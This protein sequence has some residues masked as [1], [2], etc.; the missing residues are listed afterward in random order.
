MRQLAHNIKTNLQK[1]KDRNPSSDV[2]IFKGQTLQVENDS[3]GLIPRF[4]AAQAITTELIRTPK[5]LIRKM[6]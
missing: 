5:A 2:H 1:I 3:E 4:H 6:V